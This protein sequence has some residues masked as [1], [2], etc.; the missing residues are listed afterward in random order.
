MIVAVTSCWHLQGHRLNVNTYWIKEAIR[1]MMDHGVGCILH[2]GDLFH[3]G[4]VGTREA[5]APTIV[6]ELK[7]ATYARAPIFLAE[8]NHDQ[9]AHPHLS[10]LTLIDRTAG[11]AWMG[12]C[13]YFDLCDGVACVA[14]DWSPGVSTEDWLERVQARV[15]SARHAAKLVI[16]YGHLDILEGSH[17]SGDWPSPSVKQL[18]QLGGEGVYWFFGHHHRHHQY[19]PNIQTVGALHRLRWD[20][21][22][23]PDGFTIINTDTREVQ[24]ILLNGPKYYDLT[25]PGAVAPTVFGVGDCVRAHEIIPADQTPHPDLSVAVDILPRPVERTAATVQPIPGLTAGRSPEDWFRAWCQ[26]RA[27]DPSDGLIALRNTVDEIK[28]GNINDVRLHRVTT[29]TIDD[30]IAFPG[31]GVTA[32]FTEGWNTF[33]GPS[34]SGKTTILE[35]IFAGLFG[36]W[37]TPARRDLWSG[38]SGELPSL[39]VTGIV[40]A[41]HLLA[42]RM[43]QNGTPSLKVSIDGHQTALGT[44]PTKV[45]PHLTELVGGPDAWLRS[46]FLC[47]DP[48]ADLVEATPADRLQALQRII[49]LEDASKISDVVTK[50]AKSVAREVDILRAKVD[51][52]QSDKADAERCAEEISKGERVLKNLETTMA[53]IATNVADLSSRKGHAT[54]AAEIAE[55]QKAMVGAPTPFTLQQ[56]EETVQVAQARLQALQERVDADIAYKRKLQSQ[57]AAGEAV[58]PMLSSV[59]CASNLLRCP[60]IDDAVRRKK[61]GELAASTLAE[62]KPQMY[63]KDLADARE[64]FYSATNNLRN[65]QNTDTQL[66][67]VRPRLAHLLGQHKHLNPLTAE[68]EAHLQELEVELSAI[69]NDILTLSKEVSG[70]KGRASVHAKSLEAAQ[71]HSRKLQDA[72]AR[73]VVMETL[74]CAFSRSEIPRHLLLEAIPGIQAE[75]DNTLGAS[76]LGWMRLVLDYPTSSDKAVPTPIAS[77]RGGAWVDAKLLSGGERAVARLVLRLAI[78]IWMGRVSGNRLLILDE[79]TAHVSEDISVHVASVLCS[80]VGPGKPFEQGILST[81]DEMLASLLGGA[82]RRMGGV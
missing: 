8:G 11:W 78:C 4:R 6:G 30:H 67:Y 58:L 41:G 69:N 32:G 56:A 62:E 75:I 80:V 47:Q 51:A 82:V 5:P 42:H 54:V 21:A 33:V 7:W 40:S 25:K 18:S 70:L 9:N 39:R 20:E 81:H 22:D 49:G 1:K 50:Q 45:Q 16:V 10:A 44:Q 66:M 12:W 71:E 59:G 53:R 48:Q 14:V 63:D 37:P 43:R 2:C 46:C 61:E 38:F 27:I 74:S 36:Y 68:E 24:R 35:A 26:S 23:N 3:Y 72:E 76:N 28:T 15:K 77:I 79:P 60:L 64:A 52:L 73:L 13:D 19:A 31:D 65:L 55:L 34:G 17:G 29:V 57:V